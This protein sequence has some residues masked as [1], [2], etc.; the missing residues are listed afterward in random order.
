LIHEVEQ[1]QSSEEKVKEE[2]TMMAHQHNMEPVQ[3]RSDQNLD[4]N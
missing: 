2:I 4:L 3:N 1:Q